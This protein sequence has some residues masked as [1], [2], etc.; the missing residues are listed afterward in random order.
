MTR[1]KK[2]RSMSSASQPHMQAPSYAPR[3]SLPPDLQ[4]P[5]VAN[6]KSI[7]YRRVMAK[8]EQ[9]TDIAAEARLLWLATAPRALG[10]ARDS[11]T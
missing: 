2:L 9:E 6:I 5:I 4:V 8:T 11:S 3:L 10:L 7:L 1:R